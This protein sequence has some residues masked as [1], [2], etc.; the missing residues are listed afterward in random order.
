MEAVKSSR[1][2]S[3]SRR[4]RPALSPATKEKRS[5]QDGRRT[6]W[7]HVINSV[8]RRSDRWKFPGSL[9]GVRFIRDT[10]YLQIPRS[11]LCDRRLSVRDNFPRLLVPR[12]PA[13][14]DRRAR[15]NNRIFPFLSMTESVPWNRDLSSGPLFPPGGAALIYT[16]DF[17]GIR[18]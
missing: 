9:A 18:W 3:R 12:S 2:A 10:C 11:H 17:I 14:I 13:N 8:I 6:F 15:P 7:V 4:Q 1:G 16:G 5:L